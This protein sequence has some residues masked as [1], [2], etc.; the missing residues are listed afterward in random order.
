M[1]NMSLDSSKY[2]IEYLLTVDERYNIIECPHNMK[3]GIYENI[4]N[5]NNSI[6][7]GTEKVISTVI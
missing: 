2:L 6:V 7:K 5:V 3:L 4:L 1:S